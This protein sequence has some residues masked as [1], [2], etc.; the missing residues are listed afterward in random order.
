MMWL[1]RF[2]VLMRVIFA[3]T[4]GLALAGVGAAHRPVE[5]P[6][7]AAA[8][9][10]FVA[11]GGSV[12]DLCHDAGDHGGHPARMECPACTLTGAVVLP[13][14]AA[15]ALPVPVLAQR[16]LWPAQVVAFL[17]SSF[18]PVPPARGPPVVT[19]A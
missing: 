1:L 15:V 18:T 9:A 13:Q 11:A 4:L 17:S 14:I 10:A 2:P 3:L 7:D 5:R 12:A 19:T 8:L 6:G 16:G